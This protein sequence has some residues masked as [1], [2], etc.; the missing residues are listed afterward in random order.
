[1]LLISF[2]STA[3]NISVPALEREFPDRL[4]TTISW[5]VTSFNV[6][7][8]TL[9]LIGGRLADRRG[10]RLVFVSGMLVFAIGAAASAAAP[11]L[12]VLLGARVMQAVGAAMVL[13]ASLV[14]VLP[15]YPP[16]RRATVVSLWASMGVAGATV[17]PTISAVLLSVGGWR[18]VFGVAAPIAIGAA[19]LG[20]RY[21]PESRAAERP[22]RLDTV[23]AV[24]GTVAVGCLSL[25]IVQGR[26]WGWG[27]APIAALAGALVVAAVV[28]GVRSMRHAEPLVDLGLFRVRTFAAPTVASGV[29]AAAGAATWFLYPLFMRDVWDFSVL[30]IGLGMSPGAVVMVIVTIVAGRIADQRG[31]RRLIVA[32]SVLPALGVGWMALVMSAESGY[33]L[34]FLPGTFMIGIGQGLVF[35]PLNAAALIG[36]TDDDLAS[37]NAAYNTVRF[38]GSALGVAGAAAV[39]GNTTGADRVDAFDFALW[40]LTA[41]TFVAPLVLAVAYP[42]DRRRPSAAPAAVPDRHRSPA[43]AAAG[44]SSS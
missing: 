40:L 28:F 33:A 18:L 4:L 24:A 11:T 21:L 8:V 22:G 5:V 15:S 6:A 42:A 44:Q 16:E 12:P 17:A 38:L 32:G 9:M 10:R 26:V 19:V 41:V 7:Q 39:L 1:M 14:A 30:Q 3:T 2:V 27:S 43:A 29:L 31:Y 34:G 25:V 20:Y 36:V 35:G 13:P 37:A 23:G